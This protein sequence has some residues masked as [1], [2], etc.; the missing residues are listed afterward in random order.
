MVC[1]DL[2]G[3]ASFLSLLC[4]R[5][6]ATAVGCGDNS[7]SQRPVP[8]VDRTPPVCLE[9][10]NADMCLCAGL[11]RAKKRIKI[12]NRRTATAVKKG[13]HNK[14]KGCIANGAVADGLFGVGFSAQGHPGGGAPYSLCING[15]Q[16]P[17]KKKSQSFH[18]NIGADFLTIASKSSLK[19]QFCTYVRSLHDTIVQAKIA[20]EQ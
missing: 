8:F 19:H 10:L 9:Y 13:Q 11:R 18:S 6:G 17:A 2:V 7:V 5:L 16:P 12:Q 4:W 1:R 14:P 3:V 15:F 20:T